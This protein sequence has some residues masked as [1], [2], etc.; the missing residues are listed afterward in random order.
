[1]K[2]PE[3]VS[4]L[5]ARSLADAG[6]ALLSQAAAGQPVTF[7]ASALR[8]FDSS[9]LALL[10]QWQRA[11]A[12]RGTS[13]KLQGTSPAVSARIAQLARS[14]GIAELSAPMLAAHH[15]PHPQT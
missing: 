7:D 13:L 4:Q 5:N 8:Q 3:N 1:V 14:Y 15:H 6:V 2:L 12:A 10:L 11:A 9:L